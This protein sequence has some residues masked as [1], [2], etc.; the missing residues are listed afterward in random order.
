MHNPH[1]DI[2]KKPQED[3]LQPVSYPFQMLSAPLIA[4]G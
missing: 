4:N 1:V 2:F 3:L